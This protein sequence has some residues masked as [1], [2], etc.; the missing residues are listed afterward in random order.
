[1]A[2]LSKR[3]LG[4]NFFGKKINFAGNILN[5]VALLK[6]RLFLSKIEFLDG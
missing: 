4:L 1:M 2:L 5:A 3:F 6:K